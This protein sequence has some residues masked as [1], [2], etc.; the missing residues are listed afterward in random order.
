MKE[1]LR[2]IIGVMIALILVSQNVISY[3]ANKKDLQNEQSEIDNKIDALQKEQEEI[4]AQKSEAMKNVESLIY[5]ISDSEK[6]ISNLKEKVSN[7]KKQIETKEKDIEQKNQEYN[8]QEKLLDAR[9]IALYENGSMSYLDM[10]LTASSLTDFLAKYYAAS[11]LIEYDKEL[12]KETQEKKAQIERE[13]A[14]LESNKKELDE[15]LVEQEQKA[16]ELKK[17][18]SDKQKQ[19]D[20][21]TAEEKE[22]QAKIEQF[23]EEKREIQA[24]LKRIAEEEAKKNSSSNNIVGKPSSSGYIFP[25][26]GLSKNNINN[27]KYPSYPGHTGV[28]VN[29]NVVGKNVV[30]V[31]SGTVVTSEA[32]YY[33][34]CSKCKYKYNKSSL[35]C[36]NCGKSGGLSIYDYRSYGEYVIINHHDGT[37][38]LY[39]HMIAGSRKVKAGQ[40]VS[41]GQ[42]LGIV[43]STGNSSG[44]HLHF[45]VLVNGSPVNPLPYLP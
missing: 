20:K 40:K 37:M 16:S 18:K 10:L 28:D 21:L 2:Q 13:K 15:S 14:E 34:K 27:K 42:A 32:R 12:I 30:A 33:Y 19:V 24:E 43:G 7:L 1:K 38:T 22:N 44:T 8:E 5:K 9:V 17:L 29:I 4:E 31:K 25:V 26:A 6:E 23:A 39:A 36:N 35:K 41:Q 3:A 11:E 45:E